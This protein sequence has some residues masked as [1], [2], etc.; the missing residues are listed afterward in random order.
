MRLVVF[1]L[2]FS[3]C[4][5]SYAQDRGVS[6]S[7]S[8]SGRTDIKSQSNNSS[9]DMAGIYRAMRRL[10]KELQPVGRA[11]QKDAGASKAKKAQSKGKGN[12]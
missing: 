4:A 9:D 3:C 5:G 7:N 10:Q 8:A 2:I 11:R 6:A 1:I 12:K